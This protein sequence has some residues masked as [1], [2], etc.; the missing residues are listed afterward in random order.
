MENKRAL[1]GIGW[2]RGIPPRIDFELRVAMQ[3]ERASSRVLEQLVA[4]AP[5]RGDCNQIT[6]LECPDR[7]SRTRR[8]AR[9]RATLL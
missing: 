9:I 6:I 8:K 3:R 2:C 4:D 5:C 1:R 7:V